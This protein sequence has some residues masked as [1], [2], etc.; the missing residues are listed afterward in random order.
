[1]RAPSGAGPVLRQLLGG[2]VSHVSLE[3]AV[4]L[5]CGRP[6]DTGSILLATRYNR[7]GSPVRPMQE[8]TVTGWG[9]CPEHQELADR[10]YIALVECDPEK[11]P[12]HGSTVKPEDAYRTGLVV[13]VR[14]EVAE[15]IFRDLT[16]GPVMFIEPDVTAYLQ[17]IPVEPGPAGAES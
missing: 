3:Q 6:H 7:D 15:R 12:A 10:G 1:M 13:H 14:R 9:L 5:V 17:S 2:P 8:K 4:C 11:T 16:P